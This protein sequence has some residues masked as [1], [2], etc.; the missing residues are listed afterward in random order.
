MGRCSKVG[1][2]VKDRLLLFD[3]G[4]FRYQLF[5]CIDRNGGF[6]VTRLKKNANP[7]IVSLNRLHRGRAVPVEGERLRDVIDR[8]ERDV[9]DVTVEVVFPRRAYAGRVRRARQKLRVVGIKNDDTGVYHLYITNIPEERLCAE[10]VGIVYSL[11]WQIELLFKELKTYFRLE[12]IPSR[13]VVVVESLLYAAL[14]TLVASRRVLD[15]IRQHLRHTDANLPT[16]R[17]AAVFTSVAHELL[18]AVIRRLARARG[19]LRE[20]ARML[21]HEAVDPNRK[22]HGLLRAVENGAREVEEASSNA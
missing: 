20:V 19:A 9:L 7:L 21:L 10:D 14:L 2:W 1:P 11:R 12:D 22:R 8:L 17:W 16:Q 15:A 4:Y 18:L 6:F 5:D 3:L 13:K